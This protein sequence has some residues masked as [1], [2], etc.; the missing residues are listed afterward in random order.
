M[1]KSLKWFWRGTSILGQWANFRTN[2]LDDDEIFEKILKNLFDGGFTY[3][4]H[5]CKGFLTI[6]NIPP[7]YAKSLEKISLFSPGS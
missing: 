1:T 3:V 2:F 5:L 4:K 7:S 6:S